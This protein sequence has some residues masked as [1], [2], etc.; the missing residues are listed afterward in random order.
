MTDKIMPKIDTWQSTY[1]NPVYPF[2]MDAV[3]PNVP[4]NQQYRTHMDGLQTQLTPMK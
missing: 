4:E 3:H 1:L 2:F